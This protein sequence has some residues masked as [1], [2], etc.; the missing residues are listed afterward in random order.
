M[1]CKNRVSC[2]T[3]QVSFV[4][5]WFLWY[6]Y[7]L[8]PV[9][10]IQKLRPSV[11][12]DM[13]FCFK[14]HFYIFPTTLNPFLHFLALCKAFYTVGLWYLKSHLQFQWDHDH[15]D[16]QP[17]IIL[18]EKGRTC[19]YAWLKDE[20]SPSPNFNNKKQTDL[21]L[22]CGDYQTESTGPDLNE[23]DFSFCAFI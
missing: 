1:K 2:L 18:Y 8:F 21:K 5:T 7:L 22:F 14:L 20:F 19:I 6:K 9:Q 10:F 17:E 15:C 16:F 11:R 4:C 23:R 3:N 12:V 13:Q